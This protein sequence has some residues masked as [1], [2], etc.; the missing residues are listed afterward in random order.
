MGAAE[1]YVIEGLG[2]GGSPKATASVLLAAPSLPRMD[3]TWNFTVCSEIASRAAISLFPSPLAS[4]CMTSRSRGV[5]GSGSSA[6]GRDAGLTAGNVESISPRCMT[7]SPNVAACMA[8]T[9]CCGDASVGRIVPMPA[10]VEST[11]WMV[12]HRPVELAAFIRNRP[13]LHLQMASRFETLRR[14]CIS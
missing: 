9:S 14:F 11:H 2:H 6:N 10:H 4:I 13:K 5:S 8:A 12:L 1:G 3:A 7:T